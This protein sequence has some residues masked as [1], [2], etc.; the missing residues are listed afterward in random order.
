MVETLGKREINWFITS[1]IPRAVKHSY[2]LIRAL[3][4]ID[5]RDTIKVG[6]HEEGVLSYVELTDNRFNTLG[7]LRIINPRLLKTIGNKFMDAY[8]KKKDDF[9][10]TVQRKKGGDYLSEIAY[11][12]MDSEGFKAFEEVLKR[13]AKKK[14]KDYKGMRFADVYEIVNELH[15]ELRGNIEA[16][17]IADKIIHKSIMSKGWLPRG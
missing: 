5:Y 6:D 8:E 14:N 17:T 15:P 16:K 1:P 2:F 10:D 12:V 7:H 4:L 11:E 3:R 13:A 9:L